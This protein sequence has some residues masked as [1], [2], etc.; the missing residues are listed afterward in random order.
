[1]VFDEQQ[2]C[3]SQEGLA[4]AWAVVLEEAW[5]GVKGKEMSEIKRFD[6]SCIGQHFRLC[7]IQE[8]LG[9]AWGVESEAGSEEAW[10]VV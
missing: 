10:A 8:G 4:E 9:E 7:H 2:F 1:M 3:N 6:H 5:A